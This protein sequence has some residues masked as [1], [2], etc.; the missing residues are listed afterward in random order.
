MQ[1][2]I[3]LW[4][5]A[6]GTPAPSQF[7]ASST[8][9]TTNTAGLLEQG[10]VTLLTGT[11]F[12]YQ[13]IANAFYFYLFRN[14]NPMPSQEC[15][16]FTVPFIPPNLVGLVNSILCATGSATNTDTL[17]AGGLF[18]GG[19]LSFAFL[20]GQG[21]CRTGQF[22]LYGM[23]SYT[24]PVWFD[25]SCEY[26]EP[27]IMAFQ[28]NGAGSQTGSVHA[29]GYQWDALVVN[30][31]LPRGTT[32]SYDGGTWYVITEGTDPALMIKVA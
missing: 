7:A 6:S 9:A 12:T 26:Y 15:F 28:T 11:G 29:C 8:L 17:G 27:R 25:G 20:N 32:I 30:Q 21:S 2:D 18:S 5:G 23:Q 13:L 24:K 10:A 14:A 3:W 1:G 22:S 4:R 16:Y 31:P 19:A